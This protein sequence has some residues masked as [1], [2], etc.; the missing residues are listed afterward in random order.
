MPGL[1]MPSQIDA[2]YN[3]GDDVGGIG[4]RDAGALVDGL[5]LSSE[6][7]SAVRPDSWARVKAGLR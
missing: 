3:A 7:V 5:L 6:P 2:V 4:W 1:A